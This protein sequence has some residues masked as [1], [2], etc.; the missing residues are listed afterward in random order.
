[1]YSIAKFLNFCIWSIKNHYT[2]STGKKFAEFIYDFKSYVINNPL[3]I[4]NLINRKLKSNSDMPFVNVFKLVFPFYQ[5]MNIT[6]IYV[7]LSH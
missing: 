7:Y 1:M 2:I 3:C 4:V 6:F 5:L